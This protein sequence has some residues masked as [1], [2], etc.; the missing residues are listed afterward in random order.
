MQS[1]I[2]NQTLNTIHAILAYISTK[3]QRYNFAKYKVVL[4]SIIFF[5]HYT[6]N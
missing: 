2:C 1:P 4:Q 6:L 3:L 5:N